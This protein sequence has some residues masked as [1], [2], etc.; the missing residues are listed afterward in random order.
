MS[1]KRRM[2]LSIATIALSAVLVAGRF[3]AMAADE[4]NEDWGVTA[5]I[6]LASKYLAHG[7]NLGGDSWSFQ[8]SLTLET[9]VPGVSLQVWAALPFD[10]D[11]HENDELD[12][13]LHYSRDFF[14]EDPWLMSFHGF[15]DYWVFTRQVQ[16]DSGRQFR[17]IKYKAGVAFPFLIPMFETHLVPEY[18]YYYWQ[19]I[20]SKA[21]SEGGAHEFFLR[22]AIPLRALLPAQEGQTLDLSS[23]LTYHQGSFGNETGFS[24][25]TVHMATSFA[26]GPVSISPSVN[27]QWSFED[28]INEDDEFWATF[29]VTSTF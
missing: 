20:D 18:N 9:K 24:H 14:R 26:V 28:T 13:L 17:G 12:F 25:A 29:S 27:Y 19:S 8:P 5:N 15:A 11:L 16:E 4:G 10:R 23:S 2:V 7:W 6:T 1:Y 22:H 3:Q 21:F